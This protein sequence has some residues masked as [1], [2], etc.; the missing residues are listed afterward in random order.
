MN[1]LIPPQFIGWGLIFLVFF[2]TIYL[3]RSGKLSAHLAISWVIAEIAMMLLMFFNHLRA[4]VR[5]VLGEQG[6]IYSLI[7]LGAIW[8]VFLMLEELTRISTLTSKM[9]DINQEVAMLNEE[10]SA[11]KR[12]LNKMD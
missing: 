4:W 9:K 1:S 2:Y 5:E 10:L 11:L 8:F 3:I 12:Q 7:L 6:A